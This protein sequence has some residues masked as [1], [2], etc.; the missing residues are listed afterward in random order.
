MS[1]TVLDA[2]EPGEGEGLTPDE[3]ALYHRLAADGAAWRAEGHA[4][5]TLGAQLQQ[6]ARTLT[7]SVDAANLARQLPTPPL[8]SRARVPARS[9]AGASIRGATRSH[10]RFRRFGAVAAVLVVVGGLAALRLS[11]APGRVQPI[12]PTPGTTES[13]LAATGKWVAL[14]QLDASSAFDA[15]DVPAMAPSDPRVVYE[16]FAYDGKGVASQPAQLR[17]TDDE[18]ATWHMLPLP[19]PADHISHAGIAV[20][21]LTAQTV[22]LTLFEYSA[23]NCLADHA[24]ATETGGEGPAYCWLQYTSTDSGAHW[25]ATQ[26][27]LASGTTPGTLTVSVTAGDAAPITSGALSAQGTRLYAGFGCSDFSCSRLVTSTDGGLSWQFADQPLLTSAAN[28][29]DYTNTPTGA[30]VFAV[31]TPVTG[32]WE[33]NVRDQHPLTLWRSDDAGTHWISLGQLGTPNERG[34][35]LVNDPTTHTPLL[36]AMLPRTTAI[37]TDKMGNQFPQFS[38][39][40]RDVKVSADSGRTWTAAPSLGIPA[41]QQVYVDEDLAGVLPDGS[42]VVQFIP[43][44]AQDDGSGSS[45]YAWKPGESAWRQLAPPLTK[46]FGALLVTPSKAGGVGTLWVVLVNPFTFQRDIVNPS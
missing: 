30:T 12:S 34:I 11:A 43:Q 10:E 26:L 46:E 16:T 41:G 37:G 35:R 6:R 33:C 22:F 42:V 4:I 38:S 27:P 17:R 39:D 15:N 31:T 3:Q 1:D 18:G 5:E 32:T 36:Y 8:K 9:E 2:S 20:S 40:P 21:P 24:Q 13:S 7:T 28:V 44:V 14:S 19:V 29:C 23:A 25:I 45:L